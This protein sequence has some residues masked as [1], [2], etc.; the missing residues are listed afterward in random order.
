MKGV[1]LPTETGRE[2]LQLDGAAQA[3]SFEPLS[4]R[5]DR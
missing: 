5:A 4:C 1:T 3:A 2:L